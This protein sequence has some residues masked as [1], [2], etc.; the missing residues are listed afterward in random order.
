[1]VF[2]GANKRQNLP[3][4][5]IAV[6]L[7]YSL[8]TRQR[9]TSHTKCTL[10][11]STRFA[12]LLLAVRTFIVATA[13]Q[14][15]T[16]IICTHHLPL[17]RLKDNTLFICCCLEKANFLVLTDFITCL[18]PKKPRDMAFIP[19]VLEFFQRWRIS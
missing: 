10:R 3:I 12:P 5:E 16:M 14:K 13:S 7:V 15:V 18:P 19:S 11:I 6:E 1:M 9:F 17:S 4:R 8:K 2:Q